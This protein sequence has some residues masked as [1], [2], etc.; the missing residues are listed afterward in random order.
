MPQDPHVVQL[1]SR[2]RFHEVLPNYETRIDI[3]HGLKP[4]GIET[5]ASVV[6]RLEEIERVAFRF[7]EGWD[8][9]YLGTE[10]RILGENLPDSDGKALTR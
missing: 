9:K 7:L 4:V 2:T 1:S 3:A 8:T 10:W 6:D 5:V